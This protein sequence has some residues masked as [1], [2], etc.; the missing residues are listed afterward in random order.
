[1][2]IAIIGNRNRD[3]IGCDTLCE[4]VPG[5]V[6]VQ[7]H[8]SNTMQAGQFGLHRPTGG[9]PYDEEVEIKFPLT[10]FFLDPEQGKSDEEIEASGLCEEFWRSL[11][12]DFEPA[13]LSSIE[14]GYLLYTACLKAG[15]NPEEDGF[16]I[17]AWLSHRIGLL[18][19]KCGVPDTLSQEQTSKYLEV[20]GANKPVAPL[21]RSRAFAFATALVQ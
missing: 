12:H 20:I 7:C 14:Q 17:A 16:R 6:L 1:M 18:L 11:D 19:E 3:I 8:T 5:W 4:V 13:T 10:V 15:Y 21:L 9:S 2:D